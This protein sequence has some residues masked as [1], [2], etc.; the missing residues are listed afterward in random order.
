VSVV[1]TSPSPIG[2]LIKHDLLKVNKKYIR[3]INNGR[4]IVY[5]RVHWLPF[6]A[7]NAVVEVLLSPCGKVL[8]TLPFAT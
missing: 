6:Y 1:I 3:K 7:S 2:C 4:Q 5:V 8:Y